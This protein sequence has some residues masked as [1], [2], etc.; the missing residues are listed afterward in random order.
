MAVV[1]L[2]AIVVDHLSPWVS[3]LIQRPA[4][5]LF[6]TW[7][8]RSWPSSW[9][10][11]DRNDAFAAAGYMLTGLVVCVCYQI[12]LVVQLPVWLLPGAKIA[13]DL[14]FYIINSERDESSFI[15]QN[16]EG[17]AGV[18]G[19]FAIYL[20]GVAFGRLLNPARRTVL[21]W[22]RFAVLSALSCVCL[23][24]LYFVSL[25]IVG[26]VSRRLVNLPYVVW[27]LAFNYSQ[28]VALLVLELNTNIFAGSAKELSARDAVAV[29]AVHGETGVPSV[30]GGLQ[31]VSA[32]SVIRGVVWGTSNAGSLE[33]SREPSDSSDWD[34]SEHSDD[35][36]SREGDTGSS[37][38]RLRS[39]LPGQ[40]ASV[41]EDEDESSSGGT[42]ARFRFGS[43]LRRGESGREMR[44]SHDGP[45]PSTASL[46]SL[47][48]AN[49]SSGVDG[50][51]SRC[52]LGGRFGFPMLPDIPHSVFDG[53]SVLV[54]S[55]SANLFAVFVISN[56]LVGVV[57]FSVES[58]DTPATPAVVL[59]TLYMAA[60]CVTS[61]F[62]RL[63]RISL[64]YW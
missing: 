48:A 54:E 45:A 61:V 30:D 5:Q 10:C 42:G 36:A 63:K 1:A 47:H 19:F 43:L 64:K 52:A 27:I 62:L 38:S 53:G 8:F 15:S 31:S 29:A 33:G 51:S 18:M 16:R 4:I 26:P 7:H 59:L 37:P 35:S 50:I 12:L 57:N 13:S 9:F 17:L 55:F 24:L 41:D 46:M 32:A 11:V 28:I 20:F 14:Q 34:V 56:L 23:W 2:L 39:S 58:L 49:P 25:R 6:H 60:I 22:R 21:Q 40:G 3:N 44:G